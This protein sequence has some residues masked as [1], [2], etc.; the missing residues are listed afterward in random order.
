LREAQR[1]NGRRAANVTAT[2]HRAQGG[3][4]D[5]AVLDLCDG[6]GATPTFLRAESSDE[7]GARLLIVAVT[8]PREAL[9]VIAN[10]PYLERAGG[11]VV[12]R[13]LMRL[14]ESGE[15]I[16]AATVIRATR[17]RSLSRRESSGA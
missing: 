8:R 15:V 11:A 9:V 7:A 13:L 12:R 16:D 5:V 3:E 4:V 6:P 17:S 10:I 1:G 14:R 2:V